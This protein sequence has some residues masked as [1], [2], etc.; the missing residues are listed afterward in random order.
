VRVFAIGDLHLSHSGE[1]PMDV[2]GPHWE[3]H[4]ERIRR[5]WSES[6]SSEDLVL[7]PGDISW[8]MR[9]E[10][11]LPDLDWLGR[12]PGRKVILRGNHD[13]W[14]PT[15]ARLRKALP[16]GMLALANDAIDAGPVIVAGTRGWRLPGTEGSDDAEDGRILARELI[17]LRL[18][19]DAASGLRG[20]D[21]GK[22]LVVMMHFPP[23]VDGRESPFTR[24]IT[25]SGAS[26]CVYGH[27]HAAPGRWPDGVDADLGGVRYRLASADRLDFVPLL[28]EEI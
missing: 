11:A 27:L 14:W 6:V 9:L 4:R 2:F 7:V 23:V 15:S 8:A 16:P 10:E 1:K 19:L 13:Y 5:S 18:S 22:P 3:G 24:E 20:A 28:L 25:A 17:R 26:I 21:P 12:L